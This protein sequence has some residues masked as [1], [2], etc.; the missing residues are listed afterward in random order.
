M[1][2]RIEVGGEL[3]GF[4]LAQPALPQFQLTLLKPAA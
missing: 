4:F 1:V 3:A 2:S